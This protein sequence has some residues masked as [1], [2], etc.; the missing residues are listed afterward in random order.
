MF[1][2]ALFYDYKNG[3]IT[4]P[5]AEASSIGSIFRYLLALTQLFIYYLRVLK[6][7]SAPLFDGELQ[8]PSKPNAFDNLPLQ[9]AVSNDK[10]PRAYYEQ[11]QL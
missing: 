4:T 5:H 11:L 1:I 8:S 3:E 9:S 2:K 7:K 6:D 10:L